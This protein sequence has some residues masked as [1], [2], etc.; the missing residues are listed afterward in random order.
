MG[1]PHVS[2]S[3]VVPGESLITK[4]ALDLSLLVFLLDVPLEDVTS[5]MRSTAKAI[6]F[7]LVYGQT[8][9]GLAQTL[10]ITRGEARDYIERYKERYPEIDSYMETTVASA[11]EHGN[12]RTMFGR[13]RPVA[14]LTSSNFNQRNAAR[15]VAINTP[16]QG[17]AADII[18]IAM[19]KVAALIESD[20]PEVT[21]L[22]QVHDELVFELPEASLE[23]FRL[24]V[25]EVM[26]SACSLSVPLKVDT[27]SGVNWDE[28][29]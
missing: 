21:M 29:H 28:A 3:G 8:D 6:N 16:V 4:L 24:Q 18:K 10:H 17:T 20:F 23:V 27:G 9:F 7:G 22:L 1:I 5:E 11:R 13:R 15:R 2:L 19:I 12:V 26:E 25:V 14:G